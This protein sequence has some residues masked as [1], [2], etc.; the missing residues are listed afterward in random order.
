MQELI[1]TFSSVMAALHYGCVFMY[2]CV[3]VCVSVSGR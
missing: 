2:R 1:F 3:Y